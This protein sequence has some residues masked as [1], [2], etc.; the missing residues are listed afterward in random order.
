MIAR[1][2]ATVSAIAV[3]MSA[4]HVLFIT[5]HAVHRPLSVFA[6]LPI[7]LGS[8]ASEDCLAHT[9]TLALVTRWAF[10]VFPFGIGWLL[11]GSVLIR[12]LRNRF[13]GCYCGCNARYSLDDFTDVVIFGFLCGDFGFVLAFCLFD[14][15]QA[16]LLGSYGAAELGAAEGAF[17]VFVGFDI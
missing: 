9:R 7:M 15:C 13:A 5:M 8:A 14:F 4:W 10:A 6:G 11:H 16:A 12:R 17:H 2:T 1:R 3:R